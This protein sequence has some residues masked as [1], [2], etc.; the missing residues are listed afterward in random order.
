MNTLR[1]FILDYWWVLVLIGAFAIF[2][3]FLTNYYFV[4]P[5]E[6]TCGST[7]GENIR[8]IYWQDRCLP[9]VDRYVSEGWH[10]QRYGVSG[11]D[12][13]ILEKNK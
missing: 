5:I 6:K 4:I 13:I 7:K 8:I 10:V 2:I 3:A 1:Y 9:L 12:Y 11:D